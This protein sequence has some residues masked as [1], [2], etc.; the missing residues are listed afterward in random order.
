MAITYGKAQPEKDFK[1]LIYV[2]IYKKM[3]ETDKTNWSRSERKQVLDM[4]DHNARFN[5]Q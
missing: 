1:K 4:S 2:L 5:L 3:K